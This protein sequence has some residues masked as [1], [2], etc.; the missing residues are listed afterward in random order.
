MGRGQFIALYHL[1]GASSQLLKL[2]QLNWL[3]KQR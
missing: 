1:A 3:Q 2:K